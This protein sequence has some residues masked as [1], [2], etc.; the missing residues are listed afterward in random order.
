MNRKIY[1]TVT[2]IQRTTRISN[3]GRIE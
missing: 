3:K 1:Q 2:D